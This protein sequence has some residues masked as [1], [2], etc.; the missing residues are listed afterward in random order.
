M[1]QTY[2]PIELRKLGI[3]GMRGEAERAAEWYRRAL[4]AGEQSSRSR[5]ADLADWTSRHGTA[6]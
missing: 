1:R 3:V 4:A 5:L 6:P 2:D